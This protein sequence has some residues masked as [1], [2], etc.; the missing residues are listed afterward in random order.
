VVFHS[1]TWQYL[2]DDG[3]ASTEAVFASAGA[4]ATGDAPLAWLRL[5][6]SSDLSHAELRVTTWPGGDER[7]LARCHY[8]LG[9]VRWVA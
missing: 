8:H 4:R 7:L 6:P 1:I 5:E 3:R 2:T 9:P